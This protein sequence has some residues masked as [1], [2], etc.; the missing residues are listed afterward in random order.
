M[1][2]FAC[3]ATLWLT[4]LFIQILLL[5]SQPEDIGTPFIFTHDLSVNTNQRALLYHRP[6]KINSLLLLKNTLS[7]SLRIRSHRDQHRHPRRQKRQKS[8]KLKLTL[9]LIARN[10]FDECR[11]AYLYICTRSTVNAGVA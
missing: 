1:R 6:P 8:D 3:L 10:Y 4:Y 9:Y 11:R 7:M 5:I 2:L